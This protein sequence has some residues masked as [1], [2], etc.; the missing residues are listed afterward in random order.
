M[1]GG[2]DQVLAAAA[3]ALDAGDVLSALKRVALRDDAPALAL[4]GVALSRLG[5][6][7]RARQLLQRAAKAFGA[8]APLSRA[9]CLLADAELALALR[10][11][12][13]VEAALAQASRELRALGDP[14]NAL[15]ADCLAARGLLL[16]GRLSEATR[17]L[18]ALDT[19][20]A[21]PPLLAEI[22]LAWL[23]LHL[24]TSNASAARAALREAERAAHLA[25][26][27]AISQEVR[28][29]RA[30]LEAPAGRLI[31]A[32][33]EQL[34][35]LS[36][37]ERVQRTARGLLVDARAWSVSAGSVRIT[38]EGRAVLFGLARVLA[39]AWP[40]PVAR[41]E[42]LGRVFA[43]T[44]AN[45]SHRARLR[46]EI[47]R[48][49]RAL[50][51]IATIVATPDGFRLDPSGDCDAEVG[52][53]LPVSESEHARLLTLLGDGEAWSSSALAVAL[54]VNQRTVQRSLL[55]LAAAGRARPTGG[56]RARRWLLAP[57]SEFATPLLL[58]GALSLV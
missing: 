11:L 32:G 12:R 10:D 44:R 19:R 8:A 6:R 20:R 40:A 28:T 13:G 33:K 51:P 22:H 46:V 2:A 21:S 30:L 16:R 41:R 37:V 35:G 36:Q 4:R 57:P 26:I 39:E 18:H 23:E 38:L 58:P 34:L 25:R 56:A 55:A 42:L 31:R 17:A 24:R 9:R 48:L 47:A 45:D 7:E 27:P 14:L 5:K 53:L 29:A 43:V 49:R 54:G 50:R 15:H 52:V 1:S 3:R